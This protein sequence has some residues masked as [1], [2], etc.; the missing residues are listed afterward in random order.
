MSPLE[1]IPGLH[2]ELA[3]LLNEEGIHDIAGL[4]KADALLLAKGLEIQGRK[5]GRATQVPGIIAV[6]L[7]IKAAQEKEAQAAAP[8]LD[9]DSIPEAE[10]DRSDE[11]IPEAIIEPVEAIREAIIEPALP[12]QATTPSM[13]PRRPAPSFGSQSKP[14][15]STWKGVEPSRF[16][17]IEAYAEGGR[18]IQPLKRTHDSRESAPAKLNMTKGQAL[19]RTTRRG[20]LYTWPFKAMLGALIA[21]LWRLGLLITCLALPYYS[22][23]AGESGARPIGQSLLWLGGLMV[24]GLIHLWFITHA[25]CRVCSCHLFFSKRCFKNSRAH[26]IP[27]LGYVTSLAL[28]LLLFQWFRCMYCGTAIRLFGAS[29]K[30]SSSKQAEPAEDSVQS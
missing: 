6:R 1:R 16:Q 2:A 8:M 14:D 17:T 23:V 22:F 15:E 7:F 29:S 25:R 13:A 20:V 9:F 10:P 18:G 27:G 5:R 21:L 4:A 28:H 3:S 26:L 11:D 30:H 12:S 19:S 24:L